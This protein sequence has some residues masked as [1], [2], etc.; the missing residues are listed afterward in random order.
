MKALLK[1]VLNGK[2]QILSIELN[3]S[4]TIGRTN[5]SQIVINDPMLSG[6]HCK[7]SLKSDRLEVFD[8]E[9]KNGLFLN[10][11]RVDKSEVFVNDTIKVGGCF[12]SLLPASMDPDST[13]ILSFPGPYKERMAHELKIDY[14]GNQQK[15]IEAQSRGPSTPQKAL[16][17]KLIKEVQMNKHEVK[18]KYKLRTFIAFMVDISL[19]LTC[20]ILIPVKIIEWMLVKPEVHLIGLVMM[21]ED[22]QAHR[23]MILGLFVLF[24]GGLFSIMN[25]KKKGY[26]FGEKL[27]GIKSRVTDYT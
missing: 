9:S 23:M 15:A 8:M 5:K 24:F 4:L 20:S 18:K 19:L 11:L 2:E 6:I 10:S 25:F 12:I 22:I 3:K 26:T 17:R 27:S 16:R 7:F 14:T 13:R 21:R 1:L